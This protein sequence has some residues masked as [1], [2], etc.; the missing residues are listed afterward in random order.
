[1]PPPV[2]IGSLVCRVLSQQLLDLLCVAV[3]RV[4]RLDLG[5]SPTVISVIRP[6]RELPILQFLEGRRLQIVPR[7]AVLLLGPQDLRRYSFPQTEAEQELAMVLLV[8]VDELEN[9]WW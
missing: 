6:P 1:M 7:V 9:L 8:V 4:I 5:D 3:I 2:T